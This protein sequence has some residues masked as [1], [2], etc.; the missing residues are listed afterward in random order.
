VV[1]A[2]ALF[3]LAR[4]C[5]KAQYGQA[6]ILLS[7]QQI[8]TIL[9]MGGLLEAT[10][11]LLNDYR[12]RGQLTSLFHHART[13]LT[14]VSAGLVVIYLLAAKTVM[15]SFFGH[16]SWLEHA[17]LLGGGLMLAHFALLANLYRFEEQ[18]RLAILFKSAPTVACYLSGIAGMMAARDR[19]VGFFVGCLA[20]LLVTKLIFATALRPSDAWRGFEPAILKAVHQ[21]ALPVVPVVAVGWLSGYGANFAING[22]FSRIE[23]AEFTMV[24][25]LN[26]MV[27]LV[28]NSVNQVWSPRFFKI[29]L[30]HSPQAL[31]EM[32]EV[33]NQAMLLLGS[34]FSGVVLLYFGPL[35]RL[36][37]GNAA[38]YGSIH[39]Y[40]AVTFSGYVL[41]T[42]YFRS[43]NYYF[44][45][46][47]QYEYMKIFVATGGVGFA[48]WC[49]L[50]WTMGAW[51]IY[52]GFLLCMGLRAAATYWYARREW[53]VRLSYAD[54]PLGLLIVIC[55]Y[56]LGSGVNSVLERGLL[57]AGITLG[58][59]A[60][61]YFSA[62]HLQV[63]GLSAS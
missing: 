46:R 12:S 26:A 37:G 56:A 17:A 33:A 52:L 21:N 35:L 29:A 15:P 31:E 63:R 32:N 23:V 48:V 43:L 40:L 18:H 19:V 49:L 5:S 62:R 51:G 20:G 57:F 55:G 14:M 10:T 4:V 8:I 16:L 22:L 28:I 1:Q 38:Q 61:F 50:M 58:I 30:D 53:Q 27:Q 6:G 54:I 9:A 34:I 25:S 39:P 24:L 60:L 2:F 47:R 13:A 36:I 45:K 3:W 42:A 11:S 59:S 41:L 7:L 44:L